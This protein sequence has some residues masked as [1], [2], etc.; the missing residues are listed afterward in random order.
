M[1]TVSAGKQNLRFCML[2]FLLLCSPGMAR[3]ATLTVTTTNDNGAGSLRQVIQT[4][5]P[6]DTVNFAVSG[7]IV[8]TNGEL[9]IGTNLTII[10]PGATNL[11][12]LRSSGS[13]YFR[14]F[15]VTG[16]TVSIF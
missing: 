10:G 5:A 15:N 7:T 16:G 13:G 2:L 11:T 1:K 6:G 9:V 3:A 12:I 4:A 8:L 14:L